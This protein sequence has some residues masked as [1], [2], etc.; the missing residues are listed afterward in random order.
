[1]SA[2]GPKADIGFALHMSAFEV[3]AD[4]DSGCALTLRKEV[5]QPDNKNVRDFSAARRPDI[6]SGTDR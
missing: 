3:I 6:H 2:I 1:M 5:V 4:I